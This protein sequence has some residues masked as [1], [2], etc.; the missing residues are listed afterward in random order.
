[1]MVAAPPHHGALV[2]WARVKHPSFMPSALR[3][4]AL[5]VG[6]SAGG[7]IYFR[8]MKIQSG[9]LPAMIQEGFET[10][11]KRKFIS[12]PIPARTTRI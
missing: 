9:Q 8:N 6:I 7:D 11:R 4:D 1:M 2:D 3:E 5:K 10:V 12:S